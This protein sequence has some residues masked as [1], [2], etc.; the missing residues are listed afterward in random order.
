MFLTT[1]KIFLVVYLIEL[2]LIKVN[3]SLFKKRKSKS[4][5]YFRLLTTVLKFLFFYIYFSSF[6]RFKKNSLPS[7]Y[8][9]RN[10]ILNFDVSG[11]RETFYHY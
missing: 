1:V 9:L 8:G 4:K 11:L 5:V 10:F 2:Y 6:I 3:V 7:S